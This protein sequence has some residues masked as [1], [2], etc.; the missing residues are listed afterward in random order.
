MKKIILALTLLIS[1]TGFSQEIKFGKVSKEELEEKFYPGD[2]TANAAYLFKERKTYYE[3]N[4]SLGFHVVNYYHYRLKIYNKEGLD[5]A[6]FNILYAKPESGSGEKVTNIKG[7]TFN[8]DDNGEITET[9]LNSNSIFQEKI[10]KYRSSKKITMPDVK[11]GCIIDIKYKLS[12][13]YYYYIDDVSFQT[14]IPTKKLHIEVETPDWFVFNKISKGFYS[15]IPK[16]SKKTRDIN[17][18]IDVYDAENIPA[19]RDNEPYISNIN[20]YYGGIKYELSYT[21]IPNSTIKTYA[22]TWENVSKQ[23]YKSSSFGSELEKSNYYKDDLQVI[24]STAKGDAQKAV[25]IFEF[26]KN[27]IKWNQYNSKYT[28]KGVKK[29][30]DEGTGNVA[31]INLILTAM[32]REA[33]LGANPVL[34]ST[35]NNGVPLFPTLDG[36]NYVISF[37]EFTD[38]STMLL[39]ATEKYAIPNVLPVRALNWSGRKVTKEGYSTW[40]NLNAPEHSSETNMLK[41]KIEEEGSISGLLMTKEEMLNAMLGRKRYNHFDKDEIISKLEE[42]HNIEIEN[43]R[44]SN[45]EDCYKSYNMMIKFSSDDLVESI[46]GKLLINPLLFLTEKTNPFKSDDRTFPVDFASAWKETNNISIE[47]PEGYTPEALPE[48]FA[49]GLPDNLG[50]FKFK[51]SQTGKIIE[52]NSII[53]INSPIIAPTYYSSLKEFYSKVVAKQTEKIVLVKG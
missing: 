3:Y 33:G 50:V 17:Y 24:L 15:V 52:V 53:Q 44:I 31:E 32:L 10:N 23:I 35:R 19:L 45:K 41:V 30:Y 22:D 48:Q 36:F 40:V 5:R 49:I 25:A 1:I 12:S 46:N 13:P 16:S 38:G 8:L 9:K 29:A 4:R 28:D 2:S 26:V 34:V 20:N 37:V 7:Y 11:E 27:K 47:I 14:N 39:D 51:V 43:F 42:T 6:T 21:Q 18:N